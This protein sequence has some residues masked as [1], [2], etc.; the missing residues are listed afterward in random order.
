[1]MAYFADAIPGRSASV[2]ACYNLVR[3]GVGG[4]LAAITP[5]ALRGIRS[6]WYCTVLSIM[7][8][9]ISVNLEIVRVSALRILFAAV[10]YSSMG[11]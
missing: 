6:G 1:M 2:V 9:V 10:F 4:F 5:V 3:N 7:C 11:V 8:I